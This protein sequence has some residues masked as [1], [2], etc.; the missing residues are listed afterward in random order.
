MGWSVDGKRIEVRAGFPSGKLVVDGGAAVKLAGKGE[1]AIPIGT[2]TFTFRRKP[3]VMGPKDELSFEG[4]VVPPTPALVARRDAPAG[5]RCATHADV[6]G[7]ITCARCGNFACVACT[8]ADGTHCRTCLA[9]LST[10]ARKDAAALV[11]GAPL[12]VFAIT[13][14]LLGGLF[15]GLAAAGAI[16]AARRIESTPLKVLAAIG[17]YALAIVGYVVAVGLIQGF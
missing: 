17:L 8:G 9:D 14:G 6:D 2:R 1:W 13:G 12:L 16:F 3:G 11:Y 4:E 10:R 15:G 7:V 5:G